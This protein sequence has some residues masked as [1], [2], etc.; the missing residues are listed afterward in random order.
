MGFSGRGSRGGDE[1]MAC[2]DHVAIVTS[3]RKIECCQDNA[4]RLETTQKIIPRMR[5][6]GW[7]NSIVLRK[8]SEREDL[9]LRPPVP[10]RSQ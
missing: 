8:W 3:P 9:N 5:R 4:E 1:L 10:Q 2:G 7:V 6:S